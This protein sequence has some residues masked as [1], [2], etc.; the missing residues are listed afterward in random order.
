M[1]PYKVSKRFDCYIDTYFVAILEAVGYG[2][3]RRIDPD[4]YT[5]YSMVFDALRKGSTRKAS[6]AKARIIELG[7][8]SLRGKGDPHLRW[9]LSCQF[10]KPEGGEQ[11][12]DAPRNSFGDLRKRVIC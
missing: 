2:L 3:G 6:Y 12:K 9:G 8:A 7:L 4:I 11:T 10:M 5:F 1:A